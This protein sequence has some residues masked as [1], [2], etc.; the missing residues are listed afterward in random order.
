GAVMRA[1][2]F[3]TF[4]CVLAGSLGGCPPADTIDETTLAMETSPDAAA[5]TAGASQLSSG[6]PG[7]AGPMGSP[8]AAGTQGPAGPAGPIGRT[9]AQGRAGSIDDT[10]PPAPQ[11]LHVRRR[12]GGVTDFELH[13][14]IPES[15]VALSSFE[16]YTSDDPNGD[17]GT[18]LAVVPGAARKADI[19][20]F[21]DSGVHRF[22]VVGT[23]YTGVDG[24]RSEEYVVDT[25]ARVAYVADS[26]HP[27]TSELFVVR[28]GEAPVT[29]SQPLIA[30]AAVQPPEWSPDGRM[31]MYR[32]HVPGQPYYSLF[33]GRPDG[34]VEPTMLADGEY[35]ITRFAWS[36]DA[37]HVAFAIND[38]LQLVRIDPSTLEHTTVWTSGDGYVVRWLWSPNGR[39]LA[40]MFQTSEATQAML[41][42]VLTGDVSPIDIPVRWHASWLWRPNGDQ[43]L[44]QRDYDNATSRR[45]LMQF[46]AQTGASRVALDLGQWSYDYFEM[47]PDGSRLALGGAGAYF[48]GLASLSGEEPINI[49][50]LMGLTDSEKIENWD[51]SPDGQWIRCVYRELSWPTTIYRTM[52]APA[53]FVGAEMRDLGDGY[54]GDWLPDGRLM[55]GQ[56]GAYT[57]ADPDSD[58]AIPMAVPNLGLSS[59]DGGRLLFADYTTH[60]LQVSSSLGGTPQVIAG[61]FPNA[62]HIGYLQWSPLCFELETTSQ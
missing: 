31:L 34:S 13:W 62:N 41:Y 49:R 52:V 28:P 38:V 19:Q 59:A 26:E 58:L 23:S 35:G 39:W 57:I 56:S 10:A 3:I 32:V 16:V 50:T 15:Q 22:W 14:H 42:D 48:V 55:F 36:P 44:I 60:E 9:Q 61:P 37:R 1:G 40:F 8:G 21:G 11:L 17:E 20:L 18:L 27:G 30:G 47:S 4:A 12:L 45:P 33:V 29:V 46:D 7:A 51:W 24:P 2:L 54:Y 25:Q 53:A 6:V 5:A 43:L